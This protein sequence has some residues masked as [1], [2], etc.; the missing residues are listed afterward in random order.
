MPNL[1][2]QP[3]TSQILAGGE[4]NGRAASSADFGGQIAQGLDSVGHGL[5]EGGTALNQIDQ[6]QGRVW[7]AT[8][9]SQKELAWRQGFNKQVDS[10]DP[11]SPDYPT[12]LSQLS[13]NAGKDI[14]EM[15]QNLMDQAP[16]RSA[17][18]FAGWHMA[19]AGLRMND[20]AIQTQAK[21][22]AGYTT[23]LVN[24]GVKTD[25]DMIAASPDNDTF[26]RLLEKQH[27]AIMGLSTI[28]PDVK[29]KLLTNVQHQY[30]QTQAYSAMQAN[31]QGFLTSLN[32]QGGVVRSN[33]AQVGGVPGSAPTVSGPATQP[34]QPQ[35]LAFA[36]AQLAAGKSQ[37]EA[38]Q[39]ATK[40]FPDQ[41]TKFS[42]SVPKGGTQFVDNG[43]APSS[44]DPQV[45]PL[46]EQQIAGSKPPLAGWDNLGFAEKTQLVRQAESLVGKTLASNRG[47][48]AVQFQDAMKS[49]SAG[50]DYPSLE[51]LKAQNLATLNPEEAQRRNDILDYGHQFAG[52]KAQVNTMPDAQAAAFINQYKPQGG[53]EFAAKEPIYNAAL[54]AF[55]SA[56]NDRRT[57]PIDFA[58]QN[59]I[60]GAAPLDLSTP[61]KF[62]AGLRQR[63]AVN[64]AMQ[65][66]YGAPPSIFQTTEVPQITEAISKLSSH[67]A[68]AYLG[69]MAQSLG[70]TADYH[71]AMNQL[72]A[73]EPMLGYVGHIA[74]SGATVTVGGA[75]MAATDVA[76]KV[77]D[78]SRI[79]DK[80][81]NTAKGQDPTMPAGASAIKFNETQFQAAFAKALPDAAFQSPNATQ[82]AGAQK[83]IFNAVKD[84]Y[85]ADAYAQGKPMD[86]I[87]PKA[88]QTAVDA[89]TGGVWKG[90][91]NGGVLMAPYGTK[92]ADFQAQWPGRMQ[93]ALLA[94]GHTQDDIDRNGGKL[95]PINVGDGKYRFMSGTQLLVDP[96]TGQPV[97]VDYSQPAP[98]VAA[99][100]PKLGDIPAQFLQAPY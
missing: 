81:L 15:Q 39:A 58:V 64:A 93:R 18:K 32:L 51:N 50:Q 12:Q 31:P 36:N 73:K 33:G 95:K 53:D 87:D 29:L 14:T 11:T 84:Y 85:A 82:A 94:A 49:F 63:V 6:D 99:Q 54:A 56:Q 8:A 92:M 91:G 55:G 43:V 47:M 30:S 69:Q 71:T 60:A 16:T 20:L 68:V 25:T 13:E 19:T 62:G 80:S 26:Q 97:T 61:E 3:Y 66:D 1:N 4:D 17:R 98:P 83:D 52:F 96:K 27:D 100:G 41:S 79:F 28:G 76:A 24:Q 45:Q 89:V 78:G 38:L 59:S 88:V 42:F 86:Q 67:D 44:Q 5:T 23:N 21:L 22:T 34:A 77:L 74:S 65:R 9:V 46:T 2:M 75:P 90:A 70:N 35:M 37:V 40:Q 7:A 57:K 10:L 72:G 48:G